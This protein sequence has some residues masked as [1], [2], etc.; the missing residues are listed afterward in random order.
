MLS[1]HHLQL[2]CLFALC[3]LLLPACSATPKSDDSSFTP[4]FNGRDLTGWT[5]ATQ[6][7]KPY[8]QGA[9]YQVQN[10]ILFCTKTDGGNLTTEKQYSNFTLSFEFKL[11][12]NANNGIG[13][14]AP[15]DGRISMTGMEIQ[16]LDDTGSQYTTLKPTQYHGSIY[17]AVPATRGHLKPLGQWNHQTITANA[18][19][20]TVTLN[21]QTILHANLDEV[22]DPQTL[23]THPGLQRPTGHILL[24]GHATR[25]DFRN[26]RIKEL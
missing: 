18:R 2:T 24:L 9:G 20:I 25:V 16:I 8:K 14:R 13:I 12:E 4:L 1:K 26:L 19:Q 21:G 22:K 3:L 10:G 17:D 23:K 11:T 7:N 15:S 5:Y 6:N